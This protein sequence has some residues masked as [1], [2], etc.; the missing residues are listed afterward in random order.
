MQTINML[1]HLDEITEEQRLAKA[2]TQIINKDRYRW[3]VGVV[4]TGFNEIVDENSSV[5]CPTAMTNGRDEWYSRKYVAGLSDPELR[6]LVLH[7]NSHKWM[8]DMDVWEHLAKVCARTANMAMDHVNNLLLDEENAYDK[9]A[10]MPT[11][12]D[13]N[14]TGLADPRFKGMDA[15]EVFWILYKQEDG[16]DGADGDAGEDGEDGEE[17]G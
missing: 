1:T 14:P 16:D 3:M 12:K 4:T 9:F 8:R 5:R 11:D 17:E 7:E 6:Y 15:E 10:V 2:I 13:G